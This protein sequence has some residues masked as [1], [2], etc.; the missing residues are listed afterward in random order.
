MWLHAEAPVRPA[1]GRG[2]PPVAF[3][4]SVVGLRA[5]EQAAVRREALGSKR[6]H[7]LRGFLK[8]PGGV[9]QSSM[10]NVHYAGAVVPDAGMERA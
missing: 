8:I 7:V 5:L 3:M 6:I 1:E 9:Y 2:T 10:G 4:S